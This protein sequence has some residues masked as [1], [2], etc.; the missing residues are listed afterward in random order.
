MTNTN[1]REVTLNKKALSKKAKKRAKKIHNAQCRSETVRN[2]QYAVLG[3]PVLAG[4]L[5]KFL[6]ANGVSDVE[7]VEDSP[8]DLAVDFQQSLDAV[9]Q[10]GLDR[11]DNLTD[12]EIDAV[13]AI[14]KEDE[15]FVARRRQLELT[16]VG[17]L[18][19][20][21]KPLGIK[22]GWELKKPEL[23]DAIISAEFP[24]R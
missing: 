16:G 14:L 19:K 3:E 11:I 24:A 18:R 10:A 7:P 23:I 2:H 21:I 12:E 5:S 9:L 8:V 6:Q 22:G 17:E 15:E 1:T 13:G 20:L 4:G